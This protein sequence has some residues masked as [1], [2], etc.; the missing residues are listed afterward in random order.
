[1][2]RLKSYLRR[3]RFGIF[4]FRRVIPLDLKPYFGFRQLSRS[5]HTCDPQEARCLALRF[6]ASIDLLFSRVRNMAKTP[7]PDS[8]EAELIVQLD[9]NADGTLKSV[10]TDAQPEEAEVAGRLVPE[11]IRAAKT[12]V[13]AKALIPEAV[14]PQPQLFEQINKYLDEQERGAGWTL[15]SVQDIRGDF[16]QFKWILGDQ[17]ISKLGHET[18][19]RLR[20]TLMQL[21]AS[22]NK[23]P[24]TRGKS[25]EDIL[26][27]GL[28]PQ[29]PS[30]VRKK[31]GRLITFFNWLE[32]KG[33]V[34]RNYAAGKKPKAKGQSH[35]KFSAPDLTALFESSEYQTGAF[36]EAFQYWLPLLGLFTGGRL[37][38]LAQLHLADIRMDADSGI[39][40]FDITDEID[41]ESG[42]TTTKNLKNETSRRIV[43]IHQALVDAGLLT[44]VDSLKAAGHDRLFPELRPDSVGK[45][46]PRGSEWFTEYRRSKSVGAL[47]GRSSKTFHSFRHTMNWTLQKA[48]VSLEIRESVC[49]H[50][51]KSINARIYGGAFPL[52]MLSDAMGQLKYNLEV[53]AY[54]PL[55]A[56]EVARQKGMRRSAEALAR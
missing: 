47:S 50:T 42:A 8:L 7:N 21:P 18:L 52:K 35:E 24:A 39:N 10:R 5:T 46:S 44:Y 36:A 2:I 25:I 55:P 11:L 37:E 53:A 15:Q 1:M 30:T 38:E 56:H 43:P 17:P 49:G 40:V 12:G 48:G 33:L 28:P 45:V 23:N 13:E 22:I 29:S 14:E 54:V 9:F 51:S 19:N 41:E 6:S 4:Y 16:E 31:W 20:D 32:G 26:A 34:G 27:L 3:N